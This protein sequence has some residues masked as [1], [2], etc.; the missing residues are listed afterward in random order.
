MY[1]Y[2]D[3]L[4][5]TINTNMKTRKHSEDTLINHVRL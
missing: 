2:A 1:E 5:D 3:N 4:T